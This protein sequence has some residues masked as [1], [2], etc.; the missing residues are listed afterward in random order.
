VRYWCVR[1]GRWHRRDS[2]IGKAHE[3]FTDVRRLSGERVVPV[4]A[5]EGA[6]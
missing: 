3:F 2:K 1:C 4:E 5:E 6:P